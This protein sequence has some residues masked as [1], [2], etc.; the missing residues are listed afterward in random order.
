MS[1]ENEDREDL[2]RRVAAMT[3]PVR[4]SMMT[5]LSLLEDKLANLESENTKMKTELD[6]YRR[7]YLKGRG[8]IWVIVTLGTLVWIT[9]DTLVDLI[10]HLRK[11]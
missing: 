3:A 8:A 9:W 4:K 11:P 1:S 10:M 6:Q 2:R 7:I 5:R